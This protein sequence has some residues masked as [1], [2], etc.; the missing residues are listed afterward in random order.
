MSERVLRSGANSLRLV[1]D[2]RGVV[3]A[4]LFDARRTAAELVSSLSAE[5]ATLDFANGL[6]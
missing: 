1:F 3:P 6:A 5:I 2:E 4:S